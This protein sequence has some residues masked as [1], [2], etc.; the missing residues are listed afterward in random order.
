MTNTETQPPVGREID[1]PENG[2]TPDEVLIGKSF[3]HNKVC[4]GIARRII[5]K[6]VCNLPDEQRLPICVLLQRLEPQG[7]EMCYQLAQRLGI[8]RERY[9]SIIN[10]VYDNETDF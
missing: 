8:S 5:N 3:L 6:E 4:S 9:E 1:F 7:S 2:F 10:H